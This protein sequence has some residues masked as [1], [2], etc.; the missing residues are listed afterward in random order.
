MANHAILGVLGLVLVGGVGTAAWILMGENAGLDSSGLDLKN[1][2][3]A[4]LADPPGSDELRG[5]LRDL[6]GHPECDRHPDLRRAQAWVL[7]HLGNSRRAWDSIEANLL[8]PADADLQLGA[9]ILQ[10]RHAETGDSEI[11]AQAR[12]CAEQHYQSTN[13]VASL[14]CAWQMAIRTD[15][16][17]TAARHA[18]TAQKDHADTLQAQ[19]IVAVGRYPIE[20]DS[21]L[22]AAKRFDALIDEFDEPP[23][24][25]QLAL[26]WSEIS[27]PDD[28]LAGH[29]RAEAVLRKLRVSKT[30]RTII[31]V[32]ALALERYKKSITHLEW[33][34]NTH[35][36]H[37][38]AKIWAAL[39]DKVQ[40]E[41][42][43][44]PNKQP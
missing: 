32:S 36:L 35:P 43:K 34:L 29:Q 19:V 21:S 8:D 18:A 24:E 31:A 13:D 40:S 9:E 15:D 26:A 22:A 12:S 27:R 33:L 38:K 17:E 44:G 5:L 1:R 10:A 11:A 7:Q 4:M 25:L 3:A 6:Q 39:L 37:P 28:L 23:A 30:A 41:A 42:A 20:V 16:A 14:F 2:H